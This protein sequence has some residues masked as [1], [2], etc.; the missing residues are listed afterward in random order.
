MMGLRVVGSILWMRALP[1]KDLHSASSDCSACGC[2]M[3]RPI[4]NSIC[5]GCI[6]TYSR[7]T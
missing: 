2:N 1:D 4:I 3:D 5:Q 6:C 7:L